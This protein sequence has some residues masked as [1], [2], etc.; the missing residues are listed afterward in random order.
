MPPGSGRTSGRWTTDDAATTEQSDSEAHSYIHL[1]GEDSEEDEPRQDEKDLPDAE[2]RALRAPPRK[3][4]VE[5]GG[6]IPL[7]R[8]LVEESDPIGIGGYAGES[9]PARSPARNFTVKER[10]EI[11]RIGQETGC[12]TCGTNE[13]GTPSGNFV[14]DHQPPSS[15]NFSAEPQRLYPHCLRCSRRQGSAISRLP[16]G[17]S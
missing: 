13:P 9:I 8:P 6:G 3:E 11:N 14:P 17:E 5:E 7:Q 16:K 12:H 2:R 15:L 4:D 10:Q 1:A